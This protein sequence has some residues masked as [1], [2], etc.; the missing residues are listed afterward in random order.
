M[1]NTSIIIRI[2]FAVNLFQHSPL[3]RR[4]FYNRIKQERGHHHQQHQVSER[5]TLSTASWNTDWHIYKSSEVFLISNI[6]IHN[7]MKSSSASIWISIKLI[8]HHHHNTK[9]V[10]SSQHEAGTSSQHEAGT[11][12][13]HEVGTSSQHEASTL[14]SN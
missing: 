6:V 13:Q 11:S 3:T 14:H 9:L 2:L 5:T 10:T 7:G 4:V 1:N 12:S 8:H